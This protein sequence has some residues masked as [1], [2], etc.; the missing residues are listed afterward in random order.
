[1]ALVAQLYNENRSG[2]RHSV[3][4]GG[5]VARGLGRP[6]DV[7]VDELSVSGFRMISGVP[8]A[9]GAT[10]GVTIGDL[11]RRQVIVVRQSGSRLG[12]AFVAPITN[13][14]LENMLSVPR[15]T[16]ALHAVQ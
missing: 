3:D 15:S 12:C 1:M 16:A 2:D 9:T 10:I 6:V 8:V 5:A 7:L 13:A 11:G 4:L 14:E